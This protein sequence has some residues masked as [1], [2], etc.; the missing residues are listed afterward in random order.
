LVAVERAMREH[1]KII[2]EVNPNVPHTYGN[3]IPYNALSMVVES[4]GVLPDAPARVVPL[5]TE[6]E[7]AKN[8]AKLVP[9]NNATIQVGIGNALAGM[10]EALTDK[11]HMRI[12]SELGSDWALPLLSKV[13]G[14]AP[15]VKE[16]VFSFLHG[17]NA[18]YK[19]ADNNKAIRIGSTYEVNNPATIGEQKNMRAINTALE[20]D[21]LGNVNAERIGKRI[22]SFPGGQPD[23]MKG[24][25]E[26]QD[27][28][29][30]LA[31]RSLTKTNGSTIV[32]Q[33]NGEMIT[34]PGNN[35]DHVVTEFGS[36]P[37][38]RDLDASGRASALIQVAHPIHRRALA[39]Q[40]RAAGQ[41]SQEQRDEIVA[42][43]QGAIAKAPR[44][45]RRKTAEL[46]LAN[47]I[48]TKAIYEKIIATCP[49][50]VAEAH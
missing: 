5:A 28:R 17:S 20:V 33:L 40:A 35:V 30:I 50:V 22:I 4:K 37:L 39:D 43:V 23:F 15:V 7:I 27:G 42:G 36:T 12:W 44:D 46:A 31:L 14:R 16:A 41:I 45:I 25:S 11:K 2:A 6:K 32:L 1:G 3:R 9:A 13:K 34:T 47:K 21:V 38:L 24:A 10:G 26:S 49:R 19:L 18:L 8:V 29:A 48:I